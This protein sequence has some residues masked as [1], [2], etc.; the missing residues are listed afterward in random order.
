VNEKGSK[1]SKTS[2]TGLRTDAARLDQYSLTCAGWKLLYTSGARLQRLR[3]VIE[4]KMSSARPVDIRYIAR[5]AWIYPPLNFSA[6]IRTYH[7]V[8]FYN[9]SSLPY[10]VQ[11][12]EQGFISNNATLGLAS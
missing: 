1:R 10:S 12:V 7:T 5:L 8:F 11:A 4:S 9:T 2:S 6:D 3:H